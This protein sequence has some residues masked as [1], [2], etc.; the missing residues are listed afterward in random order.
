LDFERLI[1]RYPTLYHMA[2]DGNWESIQRHG[3]LSTSALLD[4]YEVKGEERLAIESARR[5]EIIRIEHPEHGAAFIRDNKPMQQK[6]LE[7]CL[8][9]MTPREWYEH[10]N[11]RV[12]FWVEWKRLLKLLGARAY[13][14]RPHLVLEVDAAGLLDRHAD[15]VSLS[16]IN[17]G[18]TF[19]LGPA[20]RGPDTFRRIAD[21]PNGKPIVELSVDYAV[22]DIAE[23]TLRVRRWRGTEELA[24]VWSHPGQDR[25]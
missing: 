19:A 7:R 21:H 8:S 25:G 18:A 1:S 9:E 24:E 13:R 22:P 16:P 23:F 10:L 17:S 20:P 15:R 11:R 12:F 14:D 4:R 6:A 5:P 3:L 2:E